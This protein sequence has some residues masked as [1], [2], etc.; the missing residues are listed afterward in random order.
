MHK[1]TKKPVKIPVIMPKK[2]FSL[3]LL[4]YVEDN[5][6]IR[7]ITNPQVHNFMV[8]LEICILFFPRNFDS[9]LFQNINISIC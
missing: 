5:I 1:V 3:V 8:F 6:I 4:I 7:D 9:I 2:I